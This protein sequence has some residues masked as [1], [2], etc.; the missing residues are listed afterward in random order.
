MA[1]S[2]SGAMVQVYKNNQL[3]KTYTVPVEQRGTI[4]T[5]FTIENGE[6]IDKNEVGN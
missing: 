5:V 2:K 6:F 3:L 1:L 4:W